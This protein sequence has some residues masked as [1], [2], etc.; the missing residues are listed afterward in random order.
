MS[1]RYN[2]TSITTYTLMKAYEKI[3]IGLP[4]S[5]ETRS[6]SVLKM[7]SYHEI[8]H[9]I[10]V[11]MFDDMFTLQK[12]TIQSNKNGA[13]GYTLFLPKEPYTSFPSKRFLLANIMIALGGRVAE[14]I[15][16]KHNRSVQ[17]WF[18]PIKDLDITT[19]ASNDL[20]Q[21]RK[22]AKNYVE[23]FKCIGKY[24]YSNDV[25]LSEYSKREIEKEIEGI[26]MFCYEKVEEMMRTKE[27]VLH[28]LSLQ[29]LNE[30]SL[31]SASFNNSTQ[32]NYAILMDN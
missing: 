17:G 6:E 7:I 31:T 21:A 15:Y 32:I 23:L 8:G 14:Q 27:D 3:S 18:E 5:K 11:S 29:L 20:K 2:E 9:A 12:V 22:I 28:D 16:F 24:E 1:V 26:I 19:G 13:G 10:I 25:R 4:V 30:Y